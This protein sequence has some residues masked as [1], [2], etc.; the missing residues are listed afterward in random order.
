MRAASTLLA[1]STALVA[2]TAPNADTNSVCQYLYT[3][4]PNYFAWD[5]I[6]PNGGLTARNAT[7]Y[8]E[9]NQVY[10]N[11]ADSEL[12]AGCAFFP[13]NAD[14]V[15]DAVTALNKYQSAPFALK[16]GGHQPAPGFSATDGGVMISFEPNMADTVRSDDGSHFF[17]GPG[18][19]WGDV[20]K[21]TTQTNQIVVGGRLGH[22]GVA[23]L[24]LGGGLSY[25]SS[26]YVRQYS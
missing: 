10:W 1:G 9:I 4:Y 3:R 18:A 13:A 2:A 5:P 19:R 21:V 20:Y 17:V 25:Y 15:S 23:G 14:M 16:S 24:T 26:Q 11:A 6:G 8:A 7:V 12:R 22:I